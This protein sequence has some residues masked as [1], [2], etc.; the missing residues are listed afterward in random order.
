[1]DDR[2]LVNFIQAGVAEDERLRI[3]RRTKTG[4]ISKAQRLN[5]P[6]GSKRPFGREWIWHDKKRTAGAWVKDEAKQAMVK[7]VARRYVRGGSMEKLAVEHGIHPSF[8]HK[9]ITKCCGPIWIQHI[10]CP[11]V[12]IDGT[13]DTQVPPLLD[14]ETIRAIHARAEANKTYH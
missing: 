10:R 8:L 12:G 2:V 7:D 9:V 1:A 6:V 11:E 13:I 14:D 3:L 5:S 4:K